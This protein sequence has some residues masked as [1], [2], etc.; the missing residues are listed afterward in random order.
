MLFSRI[1]LSNTLI[2]MI[3]TIFFTRIKFI[4]VTPTKKKNETKCIKNN[5]FN[6]I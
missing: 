5:L 1:I 4:Y 6:L 2:I 3:I